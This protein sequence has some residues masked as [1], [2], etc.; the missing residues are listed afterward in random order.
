MSLI[1]S[2]EKQEEVKN[3]LVQRA[4]LS[5]EKE[6]LVTEK[7]QLESERK[8]LESVYSGSRYLSNQKTE[9]EA[10]KTADDNLDNK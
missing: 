3:Y 10:N 8:G 9:I 2:K 1:I 6:D 5:K 7:R 4:K